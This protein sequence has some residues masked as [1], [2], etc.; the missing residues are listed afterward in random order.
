[1]SKTPILQGIQ[2]RTQL[3]A[4]SRERGRPVDYTTIAPR[5]L[6]SY[7]AQGWTILRRN[8]AS[9]RLQRPK[10]QSIHLAAR[11][12]TLLYKMDFP[13]LSGDQGAQLV[14][15]DSDLNSPTQQL[16]VVAIDDE[17]AIAFEC[18]SVQ[19]K[20]IHPRLTEQIATHATIRGRLSHAVTHGFPSPSR[21]HVASPMVTLDIQLREADTRRA[22]EEQVAIFTEHELRYYEGLVKQLGPAARYQLLADVFRSR[23]IKGLTARIPALRTKMGS[24]NAYTF[25]VKPEYLLKIGYIAHRAKGKPSDLDAYQRMLNK[26][27]LKSIG[28]FISG[29]G[30]FPTNVVVNFD[31][32]NTRLRFD[33]GRQ[34]GDG[35]DAGGVFGWLTIEPTYGSAWI[36]DGQHRLF[37]YSGHARSNSS[38]LNV[39]AFDGLSHAKQTEMFVDVNSEQ[40]RVTRKLLVELD[41]TLKWASPDE[42][43]RINAIISRAGMAL[44]DDERSPLCGRV[45]LSDMPRSHARCVSLT[46]LASALGKPRFFVVRRAKGFREYGYLWRDD[47]SDALKRTVTIVSN[48][49]RTIADQAQDW[50]AAGSGEG[51]GLSMNDGITVCLRMLRSV[52]KHL[53]KPSEIGALRDEEVVQQCLPYA[54]SIGRYFAE[55]DP[56]QRRHFRSLRGGQGHDT[57]TRECQAALN[58]DFAEYCPGGLK[59]W[60]TRV[61]EN[62]KKQARSIIDQMEKEIQERVVSMLKEEFSLT[63][64]AWWY[65]GVPKNV[66]KKVSDRIEEQGGGEKEHYFDLLHYEAIIKSKWPLFRGTF[67]YGERKN[68]GRDKGTGWLREVAAWRNRVSHAS[69]RDYLGLAELSRLREYGDWLTAKLTGGG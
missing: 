39:V 18:K 11:V 53:G 41:A 45:L 69:R 55:M 50:W 20:N 64:T 46:A 49:L 31:H 21:R 12:W 16:D 29:G 68:I 23:R 10:P 3:L 14:F 67:A 15:D 33:R 35:A 1:M 30:V 44:D 4:L 54:E 62:T 27:R 51:G 37:A 43:K 22:E 61:K 66:R 58:G 5:D 38:Y 8:K 57:G 42:D 60:K 7:K 34:E 59:E 13:L 63:E 52:L 36:I 47:P 24:L 40:R 28:N 9:L 26:T 65:E 17:V 6:S 25:A 48:W 56:E 2:D 19:K 32:R